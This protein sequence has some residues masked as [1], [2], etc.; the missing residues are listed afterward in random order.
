MIPGPSD[1][2]IRLIAEVPEDTL[3][4][5]IPE[6]APATRAAEP[7]AWV[8]DLP[9]AIERSGLT[10][11]YRVGGREVG[12]DRERAIVVYRNRSVWN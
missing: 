7:P 4:E 12:V 11:W 9:G 3:E 10:E 8:A 2:D 1:W 6:E 5:W